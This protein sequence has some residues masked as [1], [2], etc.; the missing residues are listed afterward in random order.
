MLRELFLKMQRDQYKRFYSDFFMNAR[1][2]AD[3][4]LPAIM[5][6]SVTNAVNLYYNP[7][8][9]KEI[10]DELAMGIIEH[11]F[12]HVIKGHVFNQVSNSDLQNRMYW[13]LAMDCEINQYIPEINKRINEQVD[14][15]GGDKTKMEGCY[16]NPKSLAMMLGVT[17]DPERTSDYYY[18]L[19]KQEAEKCKGLGQPDVHEFGEEEGKGAE[20]DGIPEEIRRSVVSRLLRKVLKTSNNA[21]NIPGHL[22]HLIDNLVE[23]EVCW[24]QQL[25]RFHGMVNKNRKEFTRKK[26][27]RRYGF[28]SPGKRKVADL[29]LAVIVDTS[30]SM[31]GLIDA[32]FGEIKGMH[33]AGAHIT[34]YE[35]DT[36]LQQKYEFNP[37]KKVECKGFGG[38]LYN[39][40]IEAAMK[41]EVDGILY[42]G[43]MDCFDNEQIIKP[44]VPFMWVMLGTDKAPA[45]FGY[46]VKVK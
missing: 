1:V 31:T 18:S 29:T 20:G 23:P 44:N 27:N 9:L 28:K 10:P 19:I 30:G 5:G 24:K 11:E 36:Q 8:K 34:V 4:K 17:V 15:S 39:P 21:G 45:D 46:K 40:G 37:K 6:V 12:S 14:A 33:D 22:K 3:P 41:D 43:D 26:R 32:A 7:E 38:T 25:K 13:N 2:I 35:C 42:V 16:I